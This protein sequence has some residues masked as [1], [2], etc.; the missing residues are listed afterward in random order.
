[1]N[2]RNRAR[3]A[4]QQ[5]NELLTHAERWEFDYLVEQEAGKRGLPVP[6]R[7]KDRLEI[8]SHLIDVADSFR[9][10][11]KRNHRRVR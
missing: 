1:M 7:S 2:L 10:S 9:Q 3:L 5:A 11:Q 4:I 8:V 6:V